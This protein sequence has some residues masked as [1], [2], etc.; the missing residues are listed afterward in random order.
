MKSSRQL[1]LMFAASILASHF[2]LA[3]A[4]AATHTANSCSQQDV[5][6]AID[7]AGDGD[8]VFVPAG[9]A[10]YRTIV[11]GTPALKIK[12]K[13]IALLGAG[14]DRTVI[15]DNTY[16]TD[17]GKNPWIQRL[18]DVQGGKGKKLRISGFTFDGTGIKNA[19]K[20]VV[21]GIRGS[22]ADLR[23]DHCRFLNVNGA[24]RTGGLM[25]G[26]VDHCRYELMEDH[27]LSNPFFH[28]LEGNSA[29]A[30]KTP[31]QLGDA[32][33]IYIEDCHIEF[34]NPK[35]NDC[36]AL[37]TM[38][39]ARAVFRH[40]TVVDGFLEFFGVDSRPRGTARFEVYD[41]TFT[42]KC[43]CAIG[44]KGGT[45][46]AFNNTIEGKFNRDP[47]WVTEYRVGGPRQQIGQCDG[48]GTADGNEPLDG[49]KQTYT[50]AHSGDDGDVA[51]TC[52]GKKWK[53]NALMGYAVWN[54]TDGSVGKITA[55]TESTIT[56]ALKGGKRNRWNAR[57]ALKV[58]NGY[59]ALDQIG[60]GRDIGPDAVQ[61][62]PLEPVYAWNNTFNGAPCPLRVRRAYPR[63]EEYLREGRDFFNV[64]K[65]GYSPLA[66]PHPAVAAE[67]AASFPR[68]WSTK[69]WPG[70]PSPTSGRHTDQ[71]RAT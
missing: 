1:V 58:T 8:T 71:R 53:P 12:D 33:A 23:I 26:V 56:A 5:Q 70:T 65:P 39:G 41:N 62:Q 40:N 10:E 27:A 43:F 66:Y 6:A 21:I 59:P 28:W 45:G 42:G 16:D 11:A 29:E 36:P 7:A 20:P 30:W 37:P 64:P 4:R 34:H 49:D 67:A 69:S 3:A 51:L 46:V 17:T 47:F 2:V 60:R 18:V 15:K 52:A 68:E 48:T 22:Y 55:N 35:S 57:D 24:I 61:P 32:E 31:T 13:G 25:R 50:G 44:L 14:I 9:T 38:D 63:E 54:V 19:G